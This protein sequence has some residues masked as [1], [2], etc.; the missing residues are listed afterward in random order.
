MRVCSVSLATSKRLCFMASIAL[1]NRTLSGCFDA[2][3][4]SGLF[5][6]LFVQAQVMV[7]KRPRTAIGTT[8]R[9]IAPR[10]N[11]YLDSLQRGFGGCLQ[12]FLRVLRWI[13]L[14]EHGVACHQNF[15]AGADHVGHRVMPDAAIHFDAVRPV[16]LIA[17]LR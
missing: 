12:Q 16:A 7:S 9:D 17:N 3:L 11:D 15:P 13:T 1:S 5:A 8:R 6:F 2:I 4:A 14:T 10:K